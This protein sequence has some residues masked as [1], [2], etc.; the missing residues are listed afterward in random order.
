MR[1]PLD[2]CALRR[3]HVIRLCVFVRASAV[4][5]SADLRRCSF[6]VSPLDSSL[7]FARL[8]GDPLLE[9][10]R[11]DLI[12]AA[13]NLLDKHNLIKYDRKTGAFQVRCRSPYL[14]SCPSFPFLPSLPFR[15]DES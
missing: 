12:H 11:L 5:C 7:S 4:L 2:L 13:A 10:R 8:Q 3:L 14:W 15:G 6:V 9:Q 1:G